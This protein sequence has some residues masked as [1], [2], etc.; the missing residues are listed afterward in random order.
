MSKTAKVYIYDLLQA[1]LG[2]VSLTKV[3]FCR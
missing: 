3:S 1:M 2:F